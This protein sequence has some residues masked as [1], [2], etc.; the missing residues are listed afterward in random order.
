MCVR[1]FVCSCVPEECMHILNV[2]VELGSVYKSR[3]FLRG[4]VE[5]SAV[6]GKGC[7]LCSL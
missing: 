4:R 5:R 2:G 6:F 1:V 3:C 7:T